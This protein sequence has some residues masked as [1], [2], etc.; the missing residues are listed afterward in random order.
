MKTA[1]GTSLLIISANSLVGFVGDLQS[2]SEI[3]W[4][5]LLIFTSIAILGILVGN[6]FSTKIE[7]AKLKKGFGWFVLIMAIVI[8]GKELL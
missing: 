6:Y 2:G 1:V 4:K 5:F 7:G 8:L 3:D